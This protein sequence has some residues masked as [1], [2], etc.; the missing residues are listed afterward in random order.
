MSLIGPERRFRCAAAVFAES[1]GDRTRRVHR[2]NGARDPK[3]NSRAFTPSIALTEMNAACGALPHPA[4]LSAKRL[5]PCDA[6]RSKIKVSLF[7]PVSLC[8]NQLQIHGP[9]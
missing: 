3:E 4:A 5:P 2:E 8:H 1:E 7:D 9:V 6:P